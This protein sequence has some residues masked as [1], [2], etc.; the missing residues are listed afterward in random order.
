MAKRGTSRYTLGMKKLIVVFGSLLALA[1]VAF[2][3]FVKAYDLFAQGSSFPYEIAKALV[4]VVVVL[5]VGQIVSLI[6]YN[7]KEDQRRRGMLD[8]YRRDFVGRMRDVYTQ[9]RKASS[10]LR[11][12]QQDGLSDTESPTQ[13]FR[14]DRETLLEQIEALHDLRFA[15]LGIREEV[16]SET[17]IFSEKEEMAEDLRELYANITDL[18]RSG[19]DLFRQDT[20]NILVVTHNGFPALYDVMCHACQSVFMTESRAAYRAVVMMVHRDLTR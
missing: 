12:Q 14:I 15:L 4:Q 2:I 16:D 13:E 19:E 1:L 10:I 3:Y 6:V 9:L 7:Y 8:E 17:D 18:V 20:S 5:V 11:H